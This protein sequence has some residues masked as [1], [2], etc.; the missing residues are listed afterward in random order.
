MR[1]G[2]TPTLT[3]MVPFDTST[4]DKLYITFKQ[5][6]NQFEKTKEDCTFEESSSGEHKVITS[7]SQNETLSLS[8]SLTVSIQMAVK[9]NN[10]T[11]DR[12]NI[13]KTKVEDILK[14]GVI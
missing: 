9:F 11:V 8:D 7:L 6:N 2:T 14:E 13:I 10:G 3:F 12:S 5:A 4:I 1:R